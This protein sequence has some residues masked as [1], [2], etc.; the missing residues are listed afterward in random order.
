MRK[1]I[2]W[3]ILISIILVAIGFTTACQKEDIPTL[4]TTPA[5]TGTITSIEEREL[6]YEDDSGLGSGKMVCIPITFLEVQEGEQLKS[7]ILAG[8]HT[9][10]IQNTVQ[11]T[12]RIDN[13][14]TGKEIW[15]KYYG[16]FHDITHPRVR[17]QVDGYVLSWKKLK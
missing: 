1:K 4:N 8:P 9:L 7:F 16:G 13:E 12:Y 14:V 6:Y 15:R 17:F 11:L 5:I 3:M 10:K 2:G